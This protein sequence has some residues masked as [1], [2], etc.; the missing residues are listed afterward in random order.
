MF[1]LLYRIY[2]L[3]RRVLVGLAA[4]SASDC[5]MAQM[6]VAEI[7]AALRAAMD[8]D[9]DGRPA[10]VQTMGGVCT[11]V[12]QPVD[13]AAAACSA[14]LDEAAALD[15]ALRAAMD[16]DWEGGGGRSA[17]A[18]AAATMPALAVHG[19]RHESSMDYLP[20]EG[21]AAA[22]LM[23]PGAQAPGFNATAGAEEAYYSLPSLDGPGHVLPS[24]LD[25]M[26]LDEAMRQEIQDAVARESEL[27]DSSPPA[28]SV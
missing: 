23:M 27:A 19:S 17:A 10:T 2:N 22:S 20:L 1:P 4:S 18:L 6:S 8:E 15:A 14:S 26:Q 28:S 12:S 16:D 9:W 11:S 21:A 3:Y 24:M 7:D 5:T 13:R 25:G